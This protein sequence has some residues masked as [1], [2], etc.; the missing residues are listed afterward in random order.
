MLPKHQSHTARGFGCSGA[1]MR[2]PNNPG[3]AHG[4]A[5]RGRGHAHGPYL[6]ITADALR[7]RPVADS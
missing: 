3:T 2:Q 5:Q 4:A 6:S 7:M 1:K